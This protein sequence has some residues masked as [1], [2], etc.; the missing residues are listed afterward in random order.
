M[1]PSIPL[2]F[3]HGTQFTSKRSLL[4]FVQLAE[5]LRPEGGTG[6]HA[7]LNLGVRFFALRAVVTGGDSARH[8][9]K[10]IGHRLA[11]LQNRLDGV[12]LLALFGQV[13]DLLN[14][15]GEGFAVGGFFVC[16]VANE[17]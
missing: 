9:G 13:T 4:I 5:T 8:A 14:L 16:I 6:R 7:A 10:G 2:Y 12:V 17:K 11:L 3:F 15:F 1:H